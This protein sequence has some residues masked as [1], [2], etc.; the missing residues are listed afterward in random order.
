MFILGWE[1]ESEAAE[2]CSSVQR[3]HGCVSPSPVPVL[4][5]LCGLCV[6]ALVLLA[7]WEA[8]RTSSL[9]RC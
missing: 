6:T 9:S 8:L 5:L 3:N 7:E 1:E 4:P 2:Q